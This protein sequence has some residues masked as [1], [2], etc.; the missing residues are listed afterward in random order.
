[1]ASMSVE[2]PEVQAH[3]QEPS[4]P[5]VALLS[6]QLASG[7]WDEAGSGSA[8]VRQAR[9]TA[10]ALLE[11]L[12]AGLTTGHPLHGAQVKK[13]VAALVKLAAEIATSEARVAEFA[14]GV[15]WLV[16]T[17]R[18]TRKE[19]ELVIARHA[20]FGTLRPHVGDEQAVRTYIEQLAP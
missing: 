10:R 15:A 3:A 11:L 19:I 1:M 4:S 9:A 2:E 7:L 12:Q 17:G 18:R 6:R 20:A 8:E 13:A 16:A 14:L 5:V